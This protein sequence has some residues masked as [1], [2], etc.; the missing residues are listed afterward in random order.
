[1]DIVHVVEIHP[2]LRTP[3]SDSKAIAY[4]FA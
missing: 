2:F 4:P 3:L 1:M